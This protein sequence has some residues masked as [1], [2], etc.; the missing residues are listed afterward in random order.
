MIIFYSGS[1]CDT[2]PTFG[3]SEP[4]AVLGI[5]ADLM[6]SYYLITTQGVKQHLRFPRYLKLREAQRRVSK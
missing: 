3:W 5:R 4:E 1:S 2:R 6:M